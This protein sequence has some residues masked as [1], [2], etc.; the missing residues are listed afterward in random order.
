MHKDEMLAAANEAGLT[1][2]VPD[3]ARLTV[4]SIRLKTQKVDESAIAVGATKI[5]GLPDLPAGTAWPAWKGAAQAF[6]AQINLAELSTL[7]PIRSLP[8]TGYL[9]FFY[10]SAQDIYGSNPSDKGGWQA[11][12]FGGETSQLSR[13]P[14]PP[15]LPSGARYQACAV[16][17]SV[18]ATLPHEPQILLPRLRW[19]DAEKLGYSNF[20]ASYPSKGDRGLPHHRLLG[21]PDQLQDDMHLAVQLASHGMSINTESPPADVVKGALNWRLLFQIDTDPQAGMNWANNG[22]VYYWIE[23]DALKARQFDRVWAVLQSE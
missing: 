19:S 3:L 22:M 6:A 16:E 10:D 11:I 2:I 21:Q 9:F 13:V 23:R 5:G 1:H 20:L 17:M 12:F 15:S 18:E 14:A 4:E 7:D 8:A